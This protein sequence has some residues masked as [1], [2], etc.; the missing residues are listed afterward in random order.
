MR[1]N[2]MVPFLGA[3][4]ILNAPAIAA[5]TVPKLDVKSSCRAASTYGD[6][7]NL[8]YKGCME[9]ETQ[10]YNQL[11]QKWSHF[12]PADRA[13]CVGQVA[14]L[15]P[16]YVEVLTCLEMDDDLK[17]IGTSEGFGSIPSDQ[18]KSVPTP[19]PAPAAKDQSK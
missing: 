3:L 14:N 9:D 19:A 16:S 10:A 18:N 13:D 6:D 4:C 15:I 7:K 1:M 12:K 8:A 11:V 5:N 2:S 17:S